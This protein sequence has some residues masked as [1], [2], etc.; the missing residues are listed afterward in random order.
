MSKPLTPL[1]IANLR[2]KP[3]NSPRRY[4]VSDSGCAGLRVCVFPSGR[5]SFVVRYRFKGLP[6]KLT[7]GPCLTERDVAE[8][9]ATPEMDTPLSLAAAR[10]LCSEKLRQAK[11]GKINPVA[12]KRQ[13]REAQRAAEADTFEAVAEEFLRREGPRLRTIKQRKIDLE[14]IS[15]SVLGRQP[16]PEIKR[17][18]L[19][20]EFDR[21]ADQRGP[22]RANRVQT[23]VKALLNW[24][25]ERSDDYISC[26]TRT[27]ALISISGRARSH[28]PSDAEIAK[29]VLACERDQS[30]FGRYLLFT[31]LTACRRGESAALKRSELSPDGRTW[32]VPG[33]KYKNNRDHV[34]PLSERAA[35]IVAA[36]PV[37]A[38]GDY[39][40]SFD[41]SRPFSDFSRRKAKFD[42]A[43]GVSGWMVHDL[44]RRTDIDVAR[45]HLCRHRRISFGP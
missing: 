29:I 5:K 6:C 30:V 20:R 15:K 39:V 26:L 25:S 21:I 7:L 31:L 23:A 10:A 12:A 8:A 9:A 42:A 4:E 27:K 44:R 28:V 43:S 38:G 40:F 22:V 18:M 33:S 36:M 37:L 11:G 45:R 2:P 34:V 16:I 35:A 3:K 41:G 24:Y 13:Q 17:T 1:A 14:L 19:I 32:I